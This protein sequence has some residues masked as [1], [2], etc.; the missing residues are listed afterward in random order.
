MHTY[1]S[2]KVNANRIQRDNG[3]NEWFRYIN[4]AFGKSHFPH[5]PSNL[6][7]NTSLKLGWFSKLQKLS[8]EDR[9]LPN[10]QILRKQ[11]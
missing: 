1:L 3:G 10:F 2:L 9:G 8:Q 4:K 6:P 11:V 7:D 5:V